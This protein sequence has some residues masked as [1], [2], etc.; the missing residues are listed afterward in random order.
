MLR[1]S[2]RLLFVFGLSVF[3]SAAQA[4]DPS[5]IAGA[6]S[7]GEVFFYTGKNLAT[8]QEVAKAFETK[9]PFL[10]VKITRTSGEKLVNRIRT[11][12][13]AG[14]H[15]FDAVSMAPVPILETFSLIKPYCSR[16]AKSFAPQFK[17]PN[18][19]WTAIVGN[20]YVLV[21]N[22]RMVSK[23]EAPKDWP[24]LTQPKWRG[25]KIAMDPEEYSWL[26][27]MESY[28][29]EEKT[30]NL[31][32]ALSRQGIRWHKDHQNMAGLLAAGEFPLGLG[33]ATRTEEMKQKGA[34]IDWVRTSKPIV[35]DLHN[36]A[37]AAQPVHPNAA[38]LWIDFL[39]SHEG[40]KVLYERKEAVFRSGVIPESSPLDP[41]KFELAP[42][43]AKIF[44]KEVFAQYQSKF[45]EIFGPRR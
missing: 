26:A 35:V 45:D 15:L 41:A 38:K 21:Y 2:L 33:Y 9:Y 22:T 17:H 12:Q 19:L 20:Y 34:P 8:M 40:Q 36:L 31:M 37:M 6:K 10:R 5:T 3:H 7:E 28:L 29:G 27:G 44:S 43:P 16:E 13:L 30:R 42:V 32:T 14:K 18:C 4:R 24:D 39:L 11:E 1:Q 23:A 25:E